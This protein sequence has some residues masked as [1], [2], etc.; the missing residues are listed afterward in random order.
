MDLKNKDL[1]PCFRKKPRRSLITPEGYPYILLTLTA[2]VIAWVAWNAM[3]GIILLALT[4]YIVS[5]FR[6]PDRH[7]PAE[8]DL[9]LSPADGTILEIIECDEPRYLHK[10]AKRISIFMS[11]LN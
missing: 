4:L 10:K 9:I 1:L 3:A 2:T 7:I 5:F 11:P 8:E 6:N